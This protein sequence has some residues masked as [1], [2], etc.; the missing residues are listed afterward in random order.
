VARNEIQV[1]R[2]EYVDS[3]MSN[4]VLVASINGSLHTRLY[5]RAYRLVNQPTISNAQRS[6]YQRQV[7]KYIKFELEHHL[8][9]VAEDKAKYGLESIFPV[10]IFGLTYTG[11]SKEGIRALWS[12]LILVE[13]LLALATSWRWW[14]SGRRPEVVSILL[15]PV[16]I[17]LFEMVFDPQFRFLLPVNLLLLPFAVECIGTWLADRPGK[18]PRA[19]TK[20]SEGEGTPQVSDL[21]GTGT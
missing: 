4:A 3:V 9:A 8:T 16:F 1:H 15:Y 12:I 5:K 13:Y 14:K 17:V 19:A 7:D 2:T 10:P 6:Q 21:L 20:A 18:N 11:Q